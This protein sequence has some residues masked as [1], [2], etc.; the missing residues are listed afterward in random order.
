MVD[1]EL[2]Q[3]VGIISIRKTDVEKVWDIGYWTHPA[4]Q[5]RGYM[6][7]AARAVLDFG[8]ERLEAVSIVAQ[9]ALWN[10]AS[11]RVLRALGMEFVEYLEK[12]FEKN[13]AWVKENKMGMSRVAWMSLSGT[14]PLPEPSPLG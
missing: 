4:L 12:G 14:Q 5:G 7:E 10:I 2:E 3:R 11:E 8:F 9:Y 1:R 6:K 13:G